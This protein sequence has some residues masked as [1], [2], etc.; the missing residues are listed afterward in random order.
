[1]SLEEAKRLTAAH[2]LFSM[3]SGHSYDEVHSYGQF[4]SDYSNASV[5]SKL[6]ELCE[7]FGI[8]DMK[9]A[10]FIA[11]TR[12]CDY[13]GE[14]KAPQK[15]TNGEHVCEKCLKKLLAVEEVETD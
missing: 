13:C 3:L 7:H 14:N 8:D 4:W 5:L 11:A 15:D 2:A 6:S 12:K 1:M 10:Q 9:L